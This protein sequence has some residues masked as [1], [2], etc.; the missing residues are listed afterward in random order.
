MPLQGFFRLPQA[1]GAVAYLL[2]WTL[3]V[4]GAWIVNIRMGEEHVYQQIL[5]LARNALVKNQ[6]LRQ[7]AASHGGV[8]V[9]LGSD[10]RP[11]PFPSP[12]EERI[13]ETSSGKKLILMNPACIVRQLT[14]KGWNE[15]GETD[16][17][18]SLRP[19]NPANAP[20]PWERK[21]LETLEKGVKEFVEI[22]AGDDGAILR[23][24]RPSIMQEECLT[25]HV[26]QGYSVG[27]VHGGIGVS[28]PMKYY[29]KM[30]DHARMSLLVSCVLIWLLG[31]WGIVFLTRH[32]CRDAQARHLAEECLM[33][34][35]INLVKAQEMAHVGSWRWDLHTGVV[36][37]SDELYRIC[38]V[39]AQTF[40]PSYE[41]FMQLVLAEEHIPFRQIAN[42]SSE[43]PSDLLA[44]EY[45]IV[46]PNGVRRFVRE[47]W[48]MVLDD[49]GNP[50]Y[51]VGIVQ[52]ITE[53]KE[54][55]N[56]LRLNSERIASQERY[57]LA[58]FESALDAIVVMD[59]RGFVKNINPAAETLF[60]FAKGDLVGH[61]LSDMLVPPSTRQAHCDALA[62][63]L[64][65]PGSKLVAR[66]MEAQGMRVDGALVDLEI[67]ITEMIE[68]GEV[69]YTAFIRDVTDRK[70][71]L[72]SLNDT[73]SVAQLANRAKSEFLANMSH[74]IR[75]P[76]NAIMGMTE[77]VL[78][79]PELPE[80]LREYMEIV[81]QSSG[82]LLGIINS[83]L[84]FSKIEAGQL[85]LEHV[86]FD[87]VKQVEDACETMAINAR[88]KQ[89][90][91]FCL[92]ERDV[93]QELLGDPLRFRQILINLINNAIKF[94]Q[95]GEI[96]VRVQAIPSQMEQAGQELKISVADTGI[97]I[98]QDK[99]DEIFQAFSQADGS[100]A[101]RFGGTG[102]GLSISRRLV[103]MM[104]GEIRVESQEGKGS[105]FTFTAHFTVDESRCAVG[106]GT[107]TLPLEFAGVRVLVFD[108][109]PTG[110]DMICT[111]IHYFGAEAH[112]VDSLE[113][114]LVQMRL[115]AETGCPF[116]L[117][118]AD[119]SLVNQKDAWDSFDKE[120]SMAIHTVLLK[121][122]NVSPVAI[123]ASP[124][125]TNL[126]YVNKP[127][128]RSSL[129]SAMRQALGYD[130]Q[131]VEVTN[132]YQ[133]SL[134]QQGVAIRILLVEDRVNNQKL[135]MEILHNA[136]H[137]VTLANDGVE[138]LDMLAQHSFDLVLM[139][140]NM[141]KMNGF[142]T[143][144]R[145]R[146]PDDSLGG[147]AQVPIVVVTAT[148]VTDT[149]K[150]CTELNINGYLLKPYRPNELLKVV[151]PFTRRRRPRSKKG[152]GLAL[153]TVIAA[154]GDRETRERHRNLWMLEAPG[155]LAH[156]EQRVQQQSV[157]EVMT[158]IHWF[159]D[160]ATN[161]GAV[162]LKHRTLRLKG[163]VDL[164]DWPAAQV[165]LR[166]LTQEL[167]LIANVLNVKDDK[168]S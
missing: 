153:A 168:N 97:G 136:G 89:L 63:R 47:V 134:E 37:W 59:S 57:L 74:E 60:G 132:V 66:R 5:T 152:S 72:K 41:A 79:D 19:L 158:E 137:Q 111:M 13:I 141:P 80:S 71:L 165:G 143:I 100:M 140:L 161:M 61:L 147:H 159:L 17:I 164:R 87:V 77:L 53:Q 55:M 24:M 44:S 49:H 128:R 6:S 108:P 124:C 70:Q 129:L 127:A 45:V 85:L 115:A 51:M 78:T 27:D 54:A 138:A 98:A 48:E 91:L 3:L 12:T 104:G 10:N 167:E 133:H 40:K 81:Q 58:M 112:A 120:G 67:A 39:D 93:P 36:F 102:L 15:Q 69:M 130:A 20:D 29:Q 110:R 84:D 76:M 160:A 135:A 150:T 116:D 82:G 2:V 163:K 121:P 156:L 144:R 126:Q 96:V 83:I 139:D 88:Q 28:I 146:N 162:R 42:H 25:C 21:A 148:I 46:R 149:E 92:I 107:T 117:L 65:N 125:L 7:W 90:E 166:D 106:E 34:S 68:E 26:H 113:T 35:Q 38:G 99:L 122:M 123:Q 73:L 18:T 131:E 114:F 86:A 62:R 157:A 56:Q 8:Y 1:R 155:H 101:R 43:E 154:G 105:V 64:A 16:R 31:G 32:R 109:N 14:T 30:D 23:V 4:W 95:R 142:E 118:V 9:P 33:Q 75:S 52:D 22:V 145:I 103:D 94:T 50:Q 119:S 151:E 11:T